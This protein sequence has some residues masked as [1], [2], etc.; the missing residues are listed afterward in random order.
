MASLLDPRWLHAQ[1]NLAWKLVRHWLLKLWPWAPR[2]G[3]VRF[4]QNYVPEGLPPSS[5]AFRLLAHE[6]GRCTACNMCD[7]V[8]PILHGKLACDDPQFL[9][10]MTFVLA[11]ARQ[12]PSL[13][14][15][16][17][18]LAVLNGSPCSTC[19]ACDAVCPERIPIAKLAA[20]Y[21]DQ[22]EVIDRSRQG[23]IPITD[24]KRALPPWV[25]R[26]GSR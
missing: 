1:V 8:C 5:A 19:R 22:R 15:I 23:Q 20:I 2:Y 21:E 17:A 4:Q 3:F 16:K 12:A 7:D 25:G 6:P 11:G 10:P 18:T 13:N 14:E 24:A 9:G 26:S